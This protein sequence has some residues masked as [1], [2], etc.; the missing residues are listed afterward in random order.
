MKSLKIWTIGSKIQ[1]FQKENEGKG[2]GGWG[3]N[4]LPEIKGLVGALVAL[5][6][7]KSL[8]TFV[9]DWAHQILGDNKSM[10]KENLNTKW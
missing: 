2:E 8:W 3:E 9:W 7:S 1:W 4:L 10:P 6:N 5:G